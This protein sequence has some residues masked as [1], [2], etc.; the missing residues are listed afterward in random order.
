[1]RTM[2][3]SR[4][5][6]RG[7]MAF[8]RLSVEDCCA[9]LGPNA[10]SLN[11]CTQRDTPV[12]VALNSSRRTASGTSSGKSCAS[13]RH[14]GGSAPA[15]TA[16]GS[17]STTVSLFVSRRFT[18]SARSRPGTPSACTSLSTF[19][20]PDSEPSSAVL[21][22]AVAAAVA[23]SPVASETG[24]VST[25]RRGEAADTAEGTGAQ[26]AQPGGGG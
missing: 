1:M 20:G 21:A 14:Q 13:L 8:W 25:D 23:A 2:A 16:S 19:T 11:R 3:D 6:P 4:A 18:K 10:S 9:A 5:R 7:K 22:A 17:P 24:R 12:A 26:N 15:H